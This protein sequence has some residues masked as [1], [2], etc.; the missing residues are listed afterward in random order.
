MQLRRDYEQRHGLGKTL[1]ERLGRV[2]RLGAGVDG[3]TYLLSLEKRRRADGI[4]EWTPLTGVV[5]LVKHS[6]GCA[7]HGFGVAARV[8][9]QADARSKCCFLRGNQARGHAGIAGVE[10]SCRSAGQNFRLRSGNE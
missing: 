1:T 5:R 10:K 6:V 9:C 3:K 4:L 7:D 8:P 2:K